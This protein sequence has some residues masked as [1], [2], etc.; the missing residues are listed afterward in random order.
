MS[1]ITVAAVQAGSKLFDLE[2][3]I[4]V[5]AQ[6]LAAAKKAGAR[7]AV[8]PEAFIGGYPKGIDFGAKVGSRSPEGRDQFVQYFNGAIERRSEYMTRI[9]KFVR[10]AGLN[11]VL[12]IIERSGGT[13]YCASTTI[14]IDGDI[15]A[16]H[17]KLMPTA[18]ERII[19]GQGDGSTMETANTDI[20]TVSTAIC[21]ENY[22]PLFRSHLY[23]Q[24]T[25]IHCAPTVDDR[26]VWLPSMQMIALEGRC[27]VISACQFMT[28]S[29]VADKDYAPIQGSA[30]GTVLINGGG[31]IISPF[32]EVL[33]AP[34][35][36]KPSML[37]AEIDMNDIIR[38]KFDQD[39]AGH[40]ARPDVFSLRVN[41]A[42]QN[43]VDVKPE[44][45]T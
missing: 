41:T 31:C 8:F 35:Y 9:Q 19:W 24:G 39:I 33:A 34:V 3:T 44:G 5:F 14:G 7:L 13:L 6:K 25:Q 11:V 36:G 18:M 40:Y 43:F 27:F 16:W 32:G 20:G 15:L 38:G 22:M 17:R 21:W 12:G 30:P 23:A 28:R 26:E 2:G 45:K 42:K 29:D 37:L 4:E 10:E 1:K